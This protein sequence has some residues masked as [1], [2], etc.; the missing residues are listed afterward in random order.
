MPRD[1]LSPADDASSNHD[2]SLALRALA[3]A[4]RRW[5]LAAVAFSAVMLSALSFAR[6][7]PDLFQASAIVLVERQ[8]SESVLRPAVSGE[9]EG[10]LHV[11]KQEILSRSRLTDLITRFNLYPKLRTKQSLEAVFDQTRR[12]ILVEPNGA[13]QVSGRTKTVSF[14]LTYTGENRATVADVTNAIAAFYVDQNDQIR[15]QEAERTTQFL[16]AQLDEAKKQLEVQEQ[17]LR[18]YTTSHV[19]ELPQQVAVNLALLERLNTQLR[20]NGDQQIRV[21]EQRDRAMERPLFDISSS[22]GRPDEPALADESLERLRRL[23]RMKLDLEQTELRS[24]SK[25]PDVVRLREQI[26]ILER[27]IAEQPPGQISKTAGTDQK[28]ADAPRPVPTTRGGR[29]LE[30]VEADASRLKK[31]EADLRQTIAGV[32]RRL[33]NLPERQ[34]EFALISRDHQAAK[35]LYDSLLKKY[36]EAQLVSSVEVDRQGERFRVLEP[37]V[38]PEGPSAPNRLRIIIMG[39]LLAAAVA[40]GM[41]VAAE[42]LDTTLHSVDDLRQFTRIPVLAAIPRIGPTPGRR[43][44]RVAFATVSAVAMLV[45]ITAASAYVA[46]GNEQLVRM[47]VRGD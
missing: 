15:S 22:A 4:R 25:H 38:P 16:R 39:L 1:I 26:A 43:R 46:Q 7:L 19:G 27:E 28:P 18:N 8:L 20:I 2:E 45:L 36:D 42:Q 29:S 44:L 41:V 10:R 12:D 21:L 11:I 6:Y 34:Q 24:T 5:L 31:E 30:T 32:E 13:E 23:E 35:D 3:V 33:E 47:L 40:A 14:R 37:A 9:L 17:K